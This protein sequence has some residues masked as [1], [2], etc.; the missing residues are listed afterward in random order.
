MEAI[1]EFIYKIIDMMGMYGPILSCFLI[2]IESIM[3]ILPLGFFITINFLSYGTLIGFIISWIF[4]VIGCMLSF[5][6]FRKGVQGWFN[7]LIK[8]KDKLN[9]LMVKFN[10]ISFPELAVMISIPFMPASLFNIAAGLS[11]MD[12]KKFFAALLVGK[13]GLVYFWGYIG[14]SLVESFKE[15]I[16]L[17]KVGAIVL[18]TYIISKVLK[19]LFKF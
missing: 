18:G 14:T 9:E 3:P 16:V 10:N 2:V 8:N 1:N 12:K 4:T 7:K 6:I 19:K 13:I 11:D 5:F 15:P 17:I